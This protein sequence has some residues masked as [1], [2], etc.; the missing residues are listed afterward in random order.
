MAELID[1]ARQYGLGAAGLSVAV[2]ALAYALRLNASMGARTVEQLRALLR[3]A[4]DELAGLRATT[5]SQAELIGR[6]QREVI[7]LQ[8]QLVEAREDLS[9]YQ[10]RAARL[11]AEL[12]DLRRAIGSDGGA[13]VRML[14]R[15]QPGRHDD[16]TQRTRTPRAEDIAAIAAMRLP[17]DEE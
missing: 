9:D 6:L 5:R 17:G 16:D 3:E 1:L 11:R 14:R 8:R 13:Q 10:E 2:V 15:P 7:D 12:D 4:T